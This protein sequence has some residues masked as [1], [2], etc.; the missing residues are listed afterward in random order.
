[1]E[2]FKRTWLAICTILTGLTLLD[3]LSL[4]ETFRGA[5][6]TA[7]WISDWWI[8]FANWPFELLPFDL[9]RLFGPVL[10]VLLVLFGIA[11]K[12][13]PKLDDQRIIG[14]NW[15]TLL[16]A[17]VT[18]LGIGYVIA[19]FG[20]ASA[21]YFFP[22]TWAP[23]LFA[24][25]WGSIVIVWTVFVAVGGHNS[26]PWAVYWVRPIALVLQ[27]RNSIMAFFI[28]FAFVVGCASV[29]E[30]TV[31]LIAEKAAELPAPPC[32]SPV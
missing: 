14:V 10:S 32:A 27:N 21:E 4:I 16:L 11:S 31:P 22:F 3:I 26:H 23:Y 12:L 13:G 6:V 8:C 15:E 17:A 25:V 24:I 9:P 7:M 1:M 18:S 20:M 2:T 29:L 30:A 28:G 19:G 5:S